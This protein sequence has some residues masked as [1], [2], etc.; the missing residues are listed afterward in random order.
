[1]KKMEDLII[2]S[3][4]TEQAPMELL[5]EADP[6]E[7]MVRK[8][9]AHSHCFVARRADKTVGV[10]VLCPLQDSIMEL[11]NIAVE[12]ANQRQGIGSLLLRHAIS[13]A[14]DLGAK[15]LEV[16]T[17]SFGYQL[18]FYQKA[19]FRVYAV[20]C[21]YFLIHYDEPIIEA[22]IQHRDRLRLALEW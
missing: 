17:G 12:P 4:P 3:V 22:G 5:L 20:E 10:Y 13:S 15:R 1:M 14:R 6:S 7:D 21:D 2:Q 9:L 18:T 19:G 8:Y 11:M 16:G